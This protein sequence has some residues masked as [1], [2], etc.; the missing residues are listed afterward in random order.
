MVFSFLSFYQLFF[1]QN[2]VSKIT[3]REIKNIKLKKKNHKNYI[4]I[5]GNVV[6]IVKC[7]IKISKNIAKML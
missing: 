2:L 5:I 6:T 4:K 3:L 7:L 1:Q